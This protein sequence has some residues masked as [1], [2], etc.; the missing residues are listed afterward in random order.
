MCNEF[1][2]GG[3][4]TKESYHPV[5][6]SPPIQNLFEDKQAELGS[7][8]IFSKKGPEFSN[9]ARPDELKSTNVAHS[10]YIPGATLLIPYEV[11]LLGH[12]RYQCE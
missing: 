2:P 10:K 12:D 8:K 1:A 5:V 9:Q 11:E 4:F 6:N 3:F 7:V